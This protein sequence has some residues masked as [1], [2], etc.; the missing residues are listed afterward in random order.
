MT[1]IEDKLSYFFNKSIDHVVFDLDG[2]LIDSI[3]VMEK[4]WASATNKYDLDIPFSAFFKQIGLPFDVSMSNLKIDPKYIKDVE[5]EYSRVSSQLQG[6]IQVYPGVS[7]FLKRLGVNNIEVSIVT[8][9][10]QQRTLA[11]INEKFGD[12]EFN[13]IACP[14]SVELGRGKPFP[15][16]LLLASE[17]SGISLANTVYIGD[18]E[19]DRLVAEAAN[20][21]FIFA[22]WGYGTSNMD[23]CLSYKSVD[24]LANFIFGQGII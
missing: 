14:E 13:C 7:G 4:C 10:H 18:M 21:R 19:I 3:S 15:D 17:K 24:D 23:N 11:I 2:V 16:Q 6:Q 20:C 22:D 9:K 8:S 12:I 5:S 1:I